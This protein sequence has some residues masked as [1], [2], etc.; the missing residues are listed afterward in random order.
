MTKMNHPAAN[1]GE[2]TP[3]EIEKGRQRGEAVSFRV[4]PVP[5]GHAGEEG[6]NKERI[7]SWVIDLISLRPNSVWSLARTN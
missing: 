3:I 4:L 1:C 2:L 5:D 6:K 7:S